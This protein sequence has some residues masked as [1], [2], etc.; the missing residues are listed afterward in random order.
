MDVLLRAADHGCLAVISLLVRMALAV[1]RVRLGLPRRVRRWRGSLRRVWRGW[2]TRAGLRAPVPAFVRRRRRP[3]NRTDDHLE[4]GV[5][6][7]HVEQPLIGNGQLRHLAERVLGLRVT[8]ET[9]RKIVIR[10]RDLVVAL[11]EERRR[12]PRCIRVTG[13]RQLWGADL[14][15][16]WVLGI[17]PVWVLGVVDYHGSRLVAFERL[18]WPA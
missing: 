16:L 5:V 9:I 8:R 18:R 1:D 11:D 4:E 7:L 2:L 17:L 3:W 10:R 13:P 12:R 6:R 15:V 14:T